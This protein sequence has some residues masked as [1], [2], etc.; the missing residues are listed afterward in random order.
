MTARINRREILKA[1]TGA[2]AATFGAPYFFPARLFGAAAP[3]NR[4]S[5]GVIGTGNRGF[6][7]LDMFLKQNGAQVVA[8][9]DV[10]RGSYGYRDENQFCGR[11]PAQKLVNE[12]YSQAKKSGNYSGC[13]IYSDFREVLGRKDIDAVAVVVPDHW[14][15]LLTIRACEAGKDIY[16]EKPMSLTVEQG[17]QMVNAVRKHN[18]VLQTG[19]QERSNPR[20]VRAIELVRSGRIGQVKAVTTFVGAHN[21]VGP[22]PGWQPMPVPDGFDYET[23]LGPAPLAPYHKDRCLYR[24]R[25]NYDYSGGQVTNF[26]AHS[27]DMAQWALDADNTGPVEVELLE[28]KFLPAGSLFNAAT[29]TKFRMRYANGVELVCQL[30]KSQVG[31]RFEGTEGMIQVGYGG[32]IT[33]PESLKSTIISADEPGRRQPAS[34]RSPSTGE[35]RGEGAA[36]RKVASPASNSQLD[37]GVAHVANF[38]DCVRSRKDPIAHVETGHRSATVCH[39][40]NIAVR[41]GKKKVLHWDP[42]AERFTNDD[43]ANAMLTRPMRAPWQILPA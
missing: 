7:V 24:F 23:W 6:Q 25:F 12:H 20:T 35:G 11:E 40:G 34:S 18:R 5:V 31:A 30:D 26:G 9:C 14:H 42:A 28:A 15:A 17:R 39:L 4:L 3:S 43:E 36:Q 29:E 16:C 41:L 8:V 2:A 21:K 10:N 1:T 13:D 37:A 19:S 27:N 38:L 33:Q 22:G 32:V